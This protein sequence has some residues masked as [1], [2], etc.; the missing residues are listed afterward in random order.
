MLADTCWA[1]GQ[2]AM[3]AQGWSS[4]SSVYLQRPGERVRSGAR[5]G[6]IWAAWHPPSNRQQGICV[7]DVTPYVGAIRSFRI[8]R[9]YPC[10]GFASKFTYR[11]LEKQ[12]HGNSCES[13]WRGFETR[14]IS[15]LSSAVS[16]VMTSVETGPSQQCVQA[17]E[18][19]QVGKRD[20]AGAPQLCVCV[21]VSVCVCECVCM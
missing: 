7:L 14:V 18:A 11:D 13:R 10:P 8:L 20:T 2:V 9:I 1:Q 19:R 12:R 15:R 16:P 17:A 5:D 3:L 6:S 4:T 21:Y